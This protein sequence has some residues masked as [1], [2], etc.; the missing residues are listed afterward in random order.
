MEAVRWVLDLL[1]KNG[2]FANLKKY[3]FYQNEIYFLAYIMSA[4][5]VQMEDER[6]EAVRNWPEPKS[7]RD[8]QVFLGFDNF[9]QYFIQDFSK[10]AG[11]LTSIPRTTQSAKNLSLSM[12]E[13]SE[14]DSVGDGNC[15]DEIVEK[16]SLTSKNS[17]R[18]TGYLTPKARLA[19][20]QLR[21]AFTK[22]SIL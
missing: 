14:I 7:I 5:R 13:N 11:L 12:A 6:I 19:F 9:Y 1:R 17:N 10:I 22:A 20:T 4:Q 15:E 18:A 2:L 21:K 16:S 8:I 3:R